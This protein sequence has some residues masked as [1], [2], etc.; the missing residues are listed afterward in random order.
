MSS[1]V[2]PARGNGR[3]C[4][5]LQ[6]APRAGTIC[7]PRS[8]WLRTPRKSVFGYDPEPLELAMERAFQTAID[9]AATADGS[10]RPSAGIARQQRNPDSTSAAPWHTPAVNP[11]DFF[12]T[13]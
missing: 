9:A 10:H 2:G 5:V 11:S 8:W 7:R 3:A 4:P 12:R 1:H 6:D 13:P